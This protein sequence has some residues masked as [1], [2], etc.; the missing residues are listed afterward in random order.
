MTISPFSDASTRAWDAV[1]F[2]D[3]RKLVS[4]DYWPSDPSTDI[5][6]LE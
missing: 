4:R 5:N 1:L 2:R 3:G 6:L